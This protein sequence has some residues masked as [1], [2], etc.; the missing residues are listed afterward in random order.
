MSARKV[1]PFR[2]LLASMSLA[3]GPVVRLWAQSLYRD[4]LDIVLWHSHFQSSADTQG[5]VLFWQKNFHNAGYPIWSPS[6]KPEVLTYSDASDS[7]W[8]GFAAQHGQRAAVGNWSLK[9]SKMS[10]TFME[11]SLVLQSLC[12]SA[13]REEVSA[14]D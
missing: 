12:S 1:A 4:I 5:K 6:L 9:E 13:A 7:G 2:G 3:L 8:G 10:S 14:Q 11:V